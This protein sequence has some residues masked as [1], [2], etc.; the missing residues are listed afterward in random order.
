MS[1]EKNDFEKLHG[2]LSQVAERMAQMQ[3]LSN[4]LHD[5]EADIL[6]EQLR[7]IYSAFSHQT[8][9]VRE[10]VKEDAHPVVERLQDD[11]VVESPLSTPSSQSS[12]S[13]SESSDRT[14]ES[15]YAP[16]E[17]EVVSQPALGPVMEQIEGNPFDSLFDGAAPRFVEPPVS[18]PSVA[19]VRLEDIE[20]LAMDSRKA[21]P[22][23]TASA[24]HDVSISEP[25]KTQPAKQQKNTAA[26]TSQ[27]NEISLMDLL[28]QP[29]ENTPAPLTI[30]DRLGQAT[31]VESQVGTRVS[32][33]KVNDLR[34][35]ININDKFSFM[36]ELFHNNMKAYNDFILRLNALADR[37]AALEHVK[38]ISQEFQWDMESL[39]VKTFYSI[40]DR[41]F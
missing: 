23:Q 5:I 28:K 18:E 3:P 20:S 27:S 24:S 41:K 13:D 10:N 16:A 8:T 25:P 38:L 7:T 31:S 14:V 29:V 36:S 1:N 26:K 2:L 6:K 39:A 21:A 22:T 30:A 33:S 37:Q 15:L 34:T 32:Q 12:K 19:E 40:F 4:S 9:A 35:I 17:P 11:P